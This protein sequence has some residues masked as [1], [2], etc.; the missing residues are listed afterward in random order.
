MHTL[1]IGSHSSSH[2]LSTYFTITPAPSRSIRHLLV[3]YAVGNWHLAMTW[4]Y[5]TMLC[6]RSIATARRAAM[7]SCCSAPTVNVGIMETALA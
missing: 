1:Q 6:T 7:A 4:H 5:I 2:G 3:G